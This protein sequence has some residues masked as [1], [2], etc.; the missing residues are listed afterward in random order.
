MEMNK[1]VELQQDHPLRIVGV[2][3]NLVAEVPPKE[4]YIKHRVAGVNGKFMRLEGGLVYVAHPVS[5]GCGISSFDG[6]AVY[7][8]SEVEDAA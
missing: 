8:P 4:V 6:V 7:H 2:L 1:L 3:G 5:L